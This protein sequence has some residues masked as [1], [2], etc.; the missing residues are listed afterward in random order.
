MDTSSNSRRDEI[1][2]RLE[3]LRAEERRLEAELLAAQREET[4][5][6]AAEELDKPLVI[7]IELKDTKVHAITARKREDVLNVFKSTK[8]RFFDWN[9]DAN[10][11]PVEYWAETLDRLSNLSNIELVYKN[12]TQQELENLLNSPAYEVNTSPDDKYLLVIV[13]RA[14]S[15]IIARTPGAKLEPATKSHEARWLLPITEGWRL[16]ETLKNLERVLWSEHALS[17][18]HKDMER[19]A[20]LD[21]IALKTESPEIRAKVK[22]VDDNL[23]LRGFQEVGIEFIDAAGGRALDADQMGLGKT[24]QALGYARLH[25]L[26]ACI[27]CPASLKANW[28]REIHR[29]TGEVPYIMTGSE[30]AKYDARKLLIEKPK[31]AIINYD[32]LSR[33]TETF[34]E[35]KF[36]ETGLKS[37]VQRHFVW[38]ELI[39]L[40]DFDLIIADEAHYAKNTD[41][42]RTQA[43]MTLK[44]PRFLA[45]TGTP[46]MNRPGELWP[47]LSILYPDKFPDYNR[48]LAHYTYNGREARNVEELR[49]LLKPIMIRRLKKD[50]VKEL[51]PINRIYHWTELSGKARE[52]CNK[53]LKGIYETLAEWNPQAAGAQQKVTNLLVQIMRLK[54]VV[55]SDKAQTVADLGVEIV[56][57]LSENES[58]GAKKCIIFSQFKPIVRKIARALGHEAVWINGDLSQQERTKVIDQFKQ[59]HVIK[60]LVATSAVASEGLNLQ[61]AGAVIFTDLLWTPAAHEQCEGRAYGRLAALHSI[62]SYYVVAENSIDQMIQEILERKMRVI[63]Q[64][65]EGIDAERDGSMVMELLQKMKEEMKKK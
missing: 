44:A 19:R 40:S 25:N 54:M 3:A 8:G 37:E 57:S 27:V 28:S 43:L 15:H 36:K 2:A 62:D 18:V 17:V 48:F 47:I 11:I 35:E 60:F 9:T 64:V 6:K 1:A 45:L 49:A 29:L 39:N 50:V 7:T 4:E 5:R 32:I 21:E 26:R 63:N 16:Y 55:A 12:G 22:F 24:W 61:E 13:N 59:D 53:I 10:I 51:P 14:D 38:A 33:K 52:L 58:L 31:F 30:P 34:N 46:I 20:R 23:V 41:A 65:V 56:D 42:A